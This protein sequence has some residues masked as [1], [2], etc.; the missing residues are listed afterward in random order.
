MPVG[1]NMTLVGQWQQ[2]LRATRG[3]AHRFKK[4]QEQAVAQEAHMLAGKVVQRITRGIP[5]PLAASTRMTRRRGGTKT[6]MATGGLRRSIRAHKVSAEAWFVGI[7]KSA[8]GKGGTALYNIGSVHEHGATVLVEITE[9]SRAFLMAKFKG[10]NA[11][12]FG[13]SAGG[14]SGGTGIAVI[15]IP[16]RPFLKPTFEEHAKPADV[17][18]RFE[19][20]FAKLFLVT[21]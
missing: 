20:R 15:K 21:R 14:G 9:R 10:R 6:L 16:P 17:R 19:Q 8:R 7:L 18:K 5:P 3:L 4:A 11:G 12:T 13:G 1:V 2:A